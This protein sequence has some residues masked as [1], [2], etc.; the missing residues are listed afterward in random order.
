MLLLMAM[1]F[2]LRSPTHTVPLQQP[3]PTHKEP[4][5]P[6]ARP[7]LDPLAQWQPHSKF[8]T[9]A[10]SKILTETQS[11]S[12]KLLPKTGLMY[13]GIIAQD[14]PAGPL[15]K[16][17]W[18]TNGCPVDITDLWSTQD[19][20]EAVAYGAHP[21]ARTPTAANH[22]SWVRPPT[23]CGSGASQLCRSCQ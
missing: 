7:A 19:L 3:L 21:S 18:G 16:D 4:E 9:S 11:K 14:H 1:V 23:T 17:C 8:S 6:L 22:D 13:P 15:L 2:D 20:D 12:N 5:P 10:V